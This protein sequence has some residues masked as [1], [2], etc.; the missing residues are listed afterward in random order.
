MLDHVDVD[1]EVGPLPGAAKCSGRTPTT[2]RS[3]P[4]TQRAAAG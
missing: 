4:A 3:P 1:N 2:S